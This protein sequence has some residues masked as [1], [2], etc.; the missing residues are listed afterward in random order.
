MSM[1]DLSDLE[2]ESIEDIENIEFN[3]RV[4]DEETWDDIAITDVL[5]LN[6]E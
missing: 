4:V 1:L 5:T 3:L 6:F 2:L